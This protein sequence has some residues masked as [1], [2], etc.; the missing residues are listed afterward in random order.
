MSWHSTGLTQ[1]ENLF[2]PSTTQLQSDVSSSYF[3]GPNFSATEVNGAITPLTQ[4]AMAEPFIQ[5][6]FTPLDG[7]SSQDFENRYAFL[8]EFSADGEQFYESQCSTHYGLPNDSCHHFSDGLYEFPKQP[9]YYVSPLE[10]TAPPTQN[11]APRQASARFYTDESL[12][13]LEHA[14]TDDLIG[15]G[16]YDAPSPTPASMSFLSGPWDLPI[17]PSLGK[18]LKLE[19]TF[20]PTPTEDEESDTGQGDDDEGEEEEEQAFQQTPDMPI[21]YL[22]L[23]EKGSYYGQNCLWRTQYCI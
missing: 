14:G 20:Q 3:L 13:A 1:A 9:E 12:N 6:M 22:G 5:D 23:E 10:A 21:S 15:M 17:R 7:L 4:P 16:L 11:I 8:N 2:Q 19:E 18:G